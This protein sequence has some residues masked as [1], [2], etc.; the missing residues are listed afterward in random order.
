[1]TPSGT[2]SWGSTGHVTFTE[3]VI[4]SICMSPISVV[5]WCLRTDGTTYGNRYYDGLF[6]NTL[7]GTHD[8]DD[9]PC[10]ATDGLRSFEIIPE[11]S[12]APAYYNGDALVNGIVWGEAPVP[13]AAA[14][15]VAEQG[16]A[17]SWLESFTSCLLG[18]PVNCASGALVESARDVNVPGRGLAL[19]WRRTYVSSLAATDGPLGFGWN[20]DAGA[21]LSID[22]S[23]NATFVDGGGTP[24]V[25][26]NTT[27]GSFSAPSRVRASL[28]GNADGTYSLTQFPSQVVS[29]FSAA[30][31]L[32]TMADRNGYTTTFGY[33]G[34]GHLATVSDPSGRTLTVT[35]VGTHI[36]SVSDPMGHVTGYAYD[37]SGNLLSVT[38]PANRVTTYGYDAAHE[39]TSVTD[40]RLGQTVNTYV[41]G[42]VTRQVDPAGLASTF[43]YTGD[44]AAVTGSTT[45]MT[46][47][48][49]V[50]STRDYSQMLLQD[51]TTAIDTPQAATTAY[52]YDP[53]SLGRSLEIDPTGK[54]TRHT[55]NTHGD[56]TSG[57]DPLGLV[58]AFGN[59]S[60]DRVTSVTLPSGAQSTSSY[61]NASGVDTPNLQSS[62][63]A[64]GNV[65]TYAHAD[66]A[67]PGDVTS[68]TDPDARV[69]SM[70]YDPAGNLAT[71]TT[72]PT[73]GVNNTAEY[74]HDADSQLVCSVSA[75]KRAAGIHC[76]TPGTTPPAGAQA[77][78]YDLDGEVTAS[79]DAL[80]HTSSFLYDSDGNRTTATDPRA[81]VTKSTFDADNRA[82]SVTAAYG[83]ASASTTSTAYD[84]A[85]GT[86]ACTATVPAATYCRTSTNAAGNATV[87]Y[88]TATDAA[89][90]FTRPGGQTTTYGYDLA[91]R[92]LTETTPD[93]QVTTT[94]YDDDGRP[95]SRSYSSGSPAA[96]SYT[97]NPD[98]YR[99]AMTDGT[100]NSTYNF[101]PA[102][103]LTQT[104]ASGSTVLYA[105]DNAGHVNKITYPN[106]QNVTRGYDGAGRLTSITD[107]LGHTTTVTPDADG[108]PATTTYGNAAV[109]TSTFD[110][111]D[112]MSAITDTAAG[113]TVASFGY[114]RNAN[115]Q[116]ASTT[117]TGVTQGNESYPYTQLNQLAGVNTATYTYDAADNLTNL[118]NGTTQTFDAANQ[119]TTSTIAG[120]TTSYTYDGNGNQAAIVP[121]TGD[122]TSYAYDQ[123]QHLTAVQKGKLYQPLTP[124]RIADTRTGSGKP[125]AGQPIGP[126][127]TLNVQ[128]TG[129]GGV[130]STGVSA[131]VV[132]VTEATA[133]G[134]TFLTVF[135][136]GVSRP[137]SS[138][139]NAVAGG[140]ANNE[141]TVPVGTGGQVSIYN[142]AGTTNVVVDVLGYYSAGGAGMNTITP[143][144]IAD[145]RT[146]S[147]QPYAGHPIP[148]GGTLTVQISGTAGVPTTATTAILEA[149][150]VAPTVVGNLTAY[151]AGSARPATSNLNYQVGVILTK[152]ITAGLGTN[153]S[154]AVTFYNPSAAP[155][156]LTLDLTGYINSVGDALTPL[157]PARI[158]DTR[159][160]SGQNDAGRTMAA[161]T[162]LTI[163]VTGQGGVPANARSVV[164]NMTVP[165]NTTGGSLT[166]YPSGTHPV[167]TSLTYAPSNPAFNQVTV[168]LS[169]TGTFTIWNA[170]GT[171]DVII[172]VMGSYGPLSS[173]TYNGDGLRATR[174]T[175]TGTQNFAWDP[176]GSVPLMLTDGTISYIYDDNGNPLEQIDAASAVLYY[177]HDQYGSTRLLTNAA[178][179]VAASYTYNAYGALTG[180]TGTAD[181]PLRWNG[182]YQDTDT[183]LYYLRSRYYNPSTAQFT[184]VDPATIYTGDPYNYAGGDPLNSADPLGLFTCDSTTRTALTVGMNAVFIAGAFIPGW[185]EGPDEALMAAYDT[186]YAATTAAET[187]A[188]SIA[189]STIIAR[190]GQGAMQ[191]AGEVFSGAQGRTVEEA[192]QGVVHGSFRWTTAG[193]I[194]AAGGSV[195][196]TPELNATVGE[197]N[198]QHVDVCLGGGSCQWSDLGP[199]VTKN[200]RFGGKD[201]PFYG[202]YLGWGP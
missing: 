193:D 148:A 102:G 32:L 120:A 57:T 126:G 131:V 136:T 98:G 56:V 143:T 196:P 113:T 184:T 187:G 155:V 201:Y 55:F 181:T 162:A 11:G 16:G 133:T 90:G 74:S 118:V 65:T 167:A 188:S 190:G 116:L 163:Q 29:V 158:A 198:Y 153:P 63:D 66:T 165:G 71:S 178:G 179:A 180:H 107:W 12:T 14:P 28:T 151:P 169:P 166:A 51:V 115:G 33:D 175:T 99:T 191:N 100:G 95:T 52:S 197:T 173:Y 108:N 87:N 67:H 75:V 170:G 114:T 192:G 97:Y 202:G 50:V 119:L 128:A 77:I 17:P 154:G 26:T 69:A 60:T 42:Q 145:T 146:G 159:T 70:T 31:V 164:V 24:V 140:I 47:P 176:T 200:L 49:G 1:V 83:T 195:E 141:V 161:N 123:A 92:M 101:D 110:A 189:D 10:A 125:Y 62:T 22:G 124:A 112:Q 199:N 27:G 127:G 15:S 81:L 8:Y 5:A 7:G 109:A 72:T 104:T 185:G 93:L 59:D 129:M 106:A 4:S 76:P 172:D 94:G 37:G 177:Q 53:V 130:P 144:R 78:S 135:P 40:A 48:H 80:G 25:F 88:Y 38:D 82:L 160:G 45:T 168:K 30:G 117:P 73:A 174:A 34:G 134:S 103:R 105:H 2:A 150:V 64:D 89:A 18:D 139:V 121:A 111:T 91:G 149:T 86:G 6:T 156:N 152:E 20:F 186:G 21:H 23:G 44:P 46:D 183:G 68:V 36:V 85:A 79:T 194:R 171:A 9:Q 147:G 61:K 84:I 122:K 43:A 3:K 96:V 132:N 58:T 142:A 138:N 41:G 137:T 13:V 182:Q 35:W 19:S 39:L 157:T 54:V